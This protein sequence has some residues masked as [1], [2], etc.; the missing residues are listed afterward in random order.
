[1]SEKTPKIGIK[2]RLV[3]T[4]INLVGCLPLPLARTIGCAMGSLAWT[5][6]SRAA[7]VTL[8]NLEICFPNM[9]AE[10]RRVLAKNSMCHTGMLA[11]EI[12]ILRLRSQEWLHKHLTV[13]DDS[14]FEAA[15][16]QNKGVVIL[17]PHIGNWEVLSRTLPEHGTLSLLYLP[18]KQAYLEPV[19]VK[20]REKSGAQAFPAT[21]K[22]VINIMKA[23]K[24]GGI[25]GI[26]PD[27]NPVEGSGRFADFFGQPAYTMTLIHGILQRIQCPAVFGIAKRSDKGFQLHY[28]AAD[29]AIYD[30]DPDVSL[31]ALNHGV[32]EAIKY[33]PDQYQWEYKRFRVRPEGGPDMYHD[34]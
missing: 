22:G 6:R 21:R 28:F 30:K 9:Q 19:I 8:R 23:V 4:A 29:D 24:N 33:C 31:Q 15:L 18:P 3:I 7:K 17:A 26:L 20:A 16:A 14:A 25:T 1:M 10:L 11:L 5:F 32:E 2:A 13:D 34:C 12:C 27:Q